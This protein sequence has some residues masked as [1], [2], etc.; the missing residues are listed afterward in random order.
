MRMDDVGINVVGDLQIDA[1]RLQRTV[2][3]LK[4]FRHVVA[5]DRERPFRVGSGNRGN[6]A[7]ARGP[8]NARTVTSTRSA[9]TLESSSA[10]TPA[11]ALHLG[12]V[13][14]R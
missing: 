14:T 5:D 12:R 6:V 4:L 8:S 7:A 2:R 9:S 3:I 10:M 11:P 1:K 13:F